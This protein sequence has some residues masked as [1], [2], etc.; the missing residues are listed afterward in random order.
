[1]SRRPTNTPAGEQ[2]KGDEESLVAPLARAEGASDRP[3]TQI[4]AIP[5]SSSHRPDRVLVGLVRL[6][7][8]Q[9]AREEFQ[10]SMQF[11]DD[12]GGSG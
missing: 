6:L 9:A 5:S 2:D 8:R 11:E 10:A 7:A 3:G 12:A 4:P 1:M